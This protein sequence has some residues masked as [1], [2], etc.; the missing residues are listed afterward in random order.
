MSRKVEIHLKPRYTAQDTIDAAEEALARGASPPRD[1]VRELI[2]LARIAAD[3]THVRSR[4]R[5]IETETR[6]HYLHLAAK[7]T[8]G[9][10]LAACEEVGKAAGL[11]G[12]TVREIVR[13]LDGKN[14][15]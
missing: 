9:S 11:S 5:Q 12:H 13:A 3:G 4:V 2:A 6:N 14:A 1:V 15:D 8:G 10:E 7:F